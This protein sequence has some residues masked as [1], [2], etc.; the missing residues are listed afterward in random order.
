M[1]MQFYTWKGMVAEAAIVFLCLL[2][3]DVKSVAGYSFIL[4]F[5]GSRVGMIFAAFML[6]FML[7]FGSML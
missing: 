2:L 3:F 5:V 4:F 6:I 7:P 1:L